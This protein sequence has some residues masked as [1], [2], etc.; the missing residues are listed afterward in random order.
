MVSAF[1]LDVDIQEC[2]VYRYVRMFIMDFFLLD[3]GSSSEG[4]EAD[5]RTPTPTRGEGDPP[6]SIAQVP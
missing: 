2:F 3:A 4:T 1:N 6:S 5:H